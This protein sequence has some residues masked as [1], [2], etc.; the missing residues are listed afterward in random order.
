M[1]ANQGVPGFESPI[2]RITI[3]LTFIKGPQVD[4]WVK[5]ILEGLEQ[6]HPIDN[7]IEYT[8]LD[9]LARFES[10][11]ADSTKQE[12]TQASL[13]R[14]TF[15]FPSINQYISDFKM[16]AWKARYMIGSQE[17]MNM[18]LKGLNQFP[19]IVERVIDKTPTDY[20][21]LKQKTIVVVKN[22]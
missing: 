21:N 14:L 11:F 5:G 4:G 2:R 8:Y 16:L 7:N 3:T 13:D 9:F 6:L 18:F 22:Q 19:H 17:L 1:M 12:V 20:Y 15:C 10:Q